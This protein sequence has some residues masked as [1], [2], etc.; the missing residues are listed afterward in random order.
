[1]HILLCV[2]TFAVPSVII[3]IGLILIMVPNVFPDSLFINF[4]CTHAVFERSTDKEW[5]NPSGISSNGQGTKLPGCWQLKN[6]PSAIF[7]SSMFRL[8]THVKER[9]SIRASKQ[10]HKEI[11]PLH[12]TKLSECQLLTI[13]TDKLATFSKFV[14]SYLSK[15][16]I[17]VGF[18]LND[19]S[20]H[21]CPKFTVF[22]SP[23]KPVTRHESIL[24]TFWSSCVD[25]WCTHLN[26]PIWLLLSQLGL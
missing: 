24:F 10:R 5:N 7:Y 25:R 1:M 12:L 23:I 11:S 16:R 21:M 4:V 22:I 17:S 18:L 19:V 6:S 20:F 8:H 3:M 13:P 15:F 9:K 26:F 14:N 2:T